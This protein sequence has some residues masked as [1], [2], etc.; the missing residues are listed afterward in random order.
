MTSPIPGL[1]AWPVLIAVLLIAVGRCLLLNHKVVDQLINRALLAAIS[2]ILLREAWFEDLV[3]T[4][5]WFAD[6]DQVVHVCRQ[7]SFGSILL[8][9]AYIYGIAKL[10]DGAGATGA[11]KRQRRYTLVAV[12][13]TVVILIAGTPARRAD[14]L[15]DQAMGW[16]A[17]IAW[18][19]FYV[20]LAVIAFAIARISF[21][22]LRNA[23]PS[24]QWRERVV[25][26]GVLGL[27][28]CLGL[29]A[30]TTPIITATAVIG[31]HPAHDPEMIRKAWIFFIANVVASAVVAI[32][33]VST[34]AARVG[35]DRTG[36]YCRRL[37]PLWAD[38]TAST[39]EIV[40]PVD[41]LG[42]VEPSTRLHRMIIEIHDSLLQLRKYVPTTDTSIDGPGAAVLP[43]AV[44]IA[45]AV[46]A[47]SAGRLPVMANAVPTPSNGYLGAR[48]PGTD[49]QQLLELA[50]AWPI[51]RRIATTD[52]VDR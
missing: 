50:A 13:A 10:W 12:A 38:L 27:S 22:E 24:T 16:P 39:P 26:F 21:R 29:D 25:C 20:P 43:Y 6:H 28:I 33:L 34:V 3:G 42:H 32:P 31:D 37:H 11:W 23:D 4:L 40:L 36:R 8:C 30:I 17:V 14:Q 18:T 52:N 9:V 44:R 35:W 48:D 2:G 19:A 49:L 7:L 15:I 47:K 46:E 45:E 41:G 1:I 51:A 5:V